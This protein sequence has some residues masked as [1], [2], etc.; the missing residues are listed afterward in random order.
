MHAK[1]VTETQFHPVFP[2]AQPFHQE[3]PEEYHFQ[4]TDQS[5]ETDLDSAVRKVQVRASR[6]VEKMLGGCRLVGDGWSG[7]RGGSNFQ[8][9]R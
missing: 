3:S 6:R 4:Q 5:G 8:R 1:K 7:E 9:E 2:V